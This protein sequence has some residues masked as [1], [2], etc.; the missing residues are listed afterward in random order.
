MHQGSHG[1]A[2][3]KHYGQPAD[4]GDSAT[5]FQGLRYFDIFE[6]RANRWLIAE[7]TVILAWEHAAPPLLTT[8]S[9]STWVRGSRGDSD[10]AASLTRSLSAAAPRQQDAPGPGWE[11]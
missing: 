4:D 7:R 6:R 9:P 3:L 11:N 8:P 10:P 2:I 5:V 1:E